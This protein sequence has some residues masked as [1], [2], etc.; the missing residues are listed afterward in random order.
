MET[1]HHGHHVLEYMQAMGFKVGDH[2]HTNAI[3]Q[4]AEGKGI[5]LEEIVDAILYASTNGWIMIAG[6][7]IHLTHGGFALLNPANDNT[8]TLILPD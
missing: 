6:D 4:Y 5:G 2:T 8:E 1:N 7:R 3:L